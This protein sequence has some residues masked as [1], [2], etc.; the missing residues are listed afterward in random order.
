MFYRLYSSTSKNMLYVAMMVSVVMGGISCGEEP[1]GKQ[2]YY[3]D[4]SVV[5]LVNRPDGRPMINQ[6]IAFV[7]G[8][9]SGQPAD[10]WMENAEILVTDSDGYIKLPLRNFYY[11]VLDNGEPRFWHGQYFSNFIDPRRFFVSRVHQPVIQ[12]FPKY[13][14][15]KDVRSPKSRTDK[16][17]SDPFTPQEVQEAGDFLAFSGP[18]PELSANRFTQWECIV[19]FVPINDIPAE[20]KTDQLMKSIESMEAYGVM[21]LWLRMPDGFQASIFHRNLWPPGTL[22]GDAVTREVLVVETLVADLKGIGVDFQWFTLLVGAIGQ[23]GGAAQHR[24]SGWLRTWGDEDKE[25]WKVELTVSP[26]RFN[27]NG[28]SLIPQ[29]PIKDVYEEHDLILD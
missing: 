23:T 10:D 21:Q 13:D 29:K 15:S 8:P 24:V 4:D 12:I 17:T 25:H 11:A 19:R 7:F 14:P 22:K 18:M 9:I 27:N 1:G 6:E 16:F 20:A 28:F 5:V 2:P 3:G 26:R